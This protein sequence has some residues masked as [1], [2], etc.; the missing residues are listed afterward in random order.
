LIRPLVVA[1][2]DAN[3]SPESGNRSP[4]LAELR[5]RLSALSKEEAVELSL[6]I[7]AGLVEGIADLTGRVNELEKKSGTR[8]P[9]PWVKPN[10]APKSQKAAQKQ[11][12]KRRGSAFSRKRLD[13]TDTIYYAL[14]HCPDCDRAL[15]CGWTHR[16]RQVIDLPQVKAMVTDHVVVGRHCGVCGKNWVPKIDLS[17]QVVGQHGLGVGLMSLIGHLRSVCRLPVRS[18]RSLLETLYGVKIAIGTLVAALDCIVRRGG[19]TL[20]SM[21]NEVRGSPVKHADETGW[22][23]DG[24]NGYLW[25][26]STSTVRYMVYDRSRA[27]FVPE[28]VLGEDVK[29]TLVCDFYGAYN[30]APCLKQRCWT[31]LLRDLHGLKEVHPE[32]ANVRDWANSVTDLY[33]CAVAYRDAC[34]AAPDADA[35]SVLARR[36]KRREFES[37]LSWLAAPYLD[38]PKEVRPPQAVLAERCEKFA[39]ELFVFVERL[40][41]PSGNNAAERAIRPSVVARKI[42]GGTRSA[43]GSKTRAALMSLYGTW[44]LREQNPWVECKAMLSSSKAIPNHS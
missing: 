4:S 11:K 29:G 43:Q 17:G 32:N 10:V 39:P 33:R 9:P 15:K 37:K 13:P 27:A 40:N 28:E 19:E 8:P 31:H 18:I 5:E 23:E 34:L 30:K 26:F 35:H 25:S 1:Y 24:Q 42:S 44:Q 36:D 41:V 2:V 16:L 22:R 12:R 7:I 21:L 20:R 6:S 14:G 38:L 3:E